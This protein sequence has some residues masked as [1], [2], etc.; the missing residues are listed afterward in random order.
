MGSESF[1]RRC[2][3]EMKLFRLLGKHTNIAGFEEIHIPDQKDNFQDI[4]VVSWA[5]ETD[6]ASVIQSNH[7]LSEDQVT[8]FTYQILRALKYIHSVDIVHCDL[9][10]RNCLVTSN[11]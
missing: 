7:P 1:A 6:L 3:R 4:Y 5:Y 11:C 8:F 10:P 9:R 2:L